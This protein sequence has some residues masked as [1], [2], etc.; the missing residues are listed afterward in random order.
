MF[1]KRIPDASRSR[2]S[3]GDISLTPYTYRWKIIPHVAQIGISYLTTA[4]FIKNYLIIVPTGSSMTPTIKGDRDILVARRC[5][6]ARGRDT[7]T[8]EFEKTNVRIEIFN[9]LQKRFK[10]YYQDRVTAIGIDNFSSLIFGRCEEISKGDIVVARRNGS[11]ICKRV[12]YEAGETVKD[13]D[14]IFYYHRCKDARILKSGDIV[15]NNSV[16]LIG[17]NKVVSHDS[18]YFGALP[19]NDILAIVKWRIWP[20]HHIKYFGSKRC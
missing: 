20:L 4:A 5:D 9:L 17:D 12:A 18:R 11:L 3:P 15:P 1:N 16:W 6:T 8:D 7:T 13:C 10:R 14:G 2:D 19:E